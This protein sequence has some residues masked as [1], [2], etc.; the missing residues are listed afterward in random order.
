M[1]LSTAVSGEISILMSW[2]DESSHT[3]MSSGVISSRRQKRFT[4]IFPP[5][6]TFLPA[7]SSIFAISV[8][9]VVLPSLPV[10]P[11]FGQG[12]RRKNSSISL[13]SR[14]PRS[15]A[16]ISSGSLAVFITGARKSISSSMLSRYP[17]PNRQRNP[18][19]S[20]CALR[21][22]RV[23]SIPCS[24]MSRATGIFEIPSPTKPIFLPV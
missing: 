2:N 8:V 22:R 20:G 10:T 17:S 13:V 11:I 9:V 15:F 4:P 16:A 5:R 24:N 21:S 23:T 1:F 6:N 7:D 3:A 14:T 18:S 12:Q 19:I